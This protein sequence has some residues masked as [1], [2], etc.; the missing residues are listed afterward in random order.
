VISG[1]AKRV[2]IYTASLLIAPTPIMAYE[3]GTRDFAL[4]VL[5]CG[6]IFSVSSLY[7]VGGERRLKSRSL[8]NLK[9]LATASITFLF[10]LFMAIG[11]MVFLVRF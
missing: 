2:V 6:V 1:R 11:S 3:K 4:A 7:V 10:G 9:L 8:L 5:A